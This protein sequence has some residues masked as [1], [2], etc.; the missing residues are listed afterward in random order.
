MP[1]SVYPPS[2]RTP[3]RNAV[4]DPS[5]VLHLPD[6]R[7]IGVQRY[8]ARE[9]RAFFYFHGTPGSRFEAAL[10][11]SAAAEYG[12]TLYSVERPGYGLSDPC[13]T[14]TLYDWPL[15]IAALADAMAL[16]RFGVIGVSGGGPYALACAHRIAHRLDSVGVVCGLGPV[17]RRSL[18]ARLS[19]YE[20]TAFFLER[21][22]PA[23]FSLLY[24]SP[25]AL[26]AIRAPHTLV[27]L[28][29][30][31]CGGED[32]RVLSQR[33]VL[34]GI[35]KSLPQAFAQGA[36]AATRDL[37]LYQRPWGFELAHVEHPVF[38]W[39]GSADPVVPLAHTVY[40]DSV[41]PRSTFIPVADAGHFSLPVLQA[42]EILSTLTASR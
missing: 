34:E 14:R 15:D 4:T 35:A 41:L 9:G 8:G 12:V 38:L 10:V 32:R 2:S 37:H 16:P 26:L 18:A 24:A 28:L 39:H 3:S 36:G 1:A 22:H 19:V 23:L 11:D 20:R 33:W 6:G 13:P 7:R 17:Y 27:R 21:N 40:M 42:R 25:L 30:M 31:H 29:A 5:D